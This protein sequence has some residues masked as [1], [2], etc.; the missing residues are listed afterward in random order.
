MADGTLKRVVARFQNYAGRY[1]LLDIGCESQSPE[2]GTNN[3]SVW[4]K[5]RVWAGLVSG[6]GPE[7]N[8]GSVS[9]FRRWYCETRG[10]QLPKLR[11]TKT[12]PSGCESQN[13]V[14]TT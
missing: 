7:E 6:R 3:V 4:Y 8:S 9:L 10:G 2:S 13:L 5:R 12:S 14:Q 1:F 11:R